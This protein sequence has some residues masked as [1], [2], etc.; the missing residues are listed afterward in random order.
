MG[1]VIR[2]SSYYDVCQVTVWVMLLWVITFPLTFVMNVSVD[3]SHINYGDVTGTC[4]MSVVKSCGLDVTCPRRGAE[5][6]PP[7]KG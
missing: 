1:S 2:S 6:Y 5:A 7:A 3:T 4:L